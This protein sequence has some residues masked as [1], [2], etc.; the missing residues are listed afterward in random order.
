MR[1]ARGRF[2][3]TARCFVARRRIPDVYFQARE[4]VESFLPGHPTIVQNAMDKFARLVGRQ[5][6]LFDYVG[7]PDAERVIVIMGSG[8]EVAQE[9]VEA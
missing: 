5:Y 4:A 2:R 9:S 1:I 8:A 6:H 3:P 7:A